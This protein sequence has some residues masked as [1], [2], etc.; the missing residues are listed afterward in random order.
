MLCAAGIS[1][2]AQTVVDVQPVDSAYLVQLEQIML[3]MEK[4]EKARKIIADYEKTMLR[5]ELSFNATGSM[6][7][8][9]G[10]M[11]T[12][13]NNDYRK[14]APKF[15]D[16]SDDWRDYA[17]ASIPGVAT[18][19]ARLC[20][21]KSRSNLN[22]MFT[23]TAMSLAL[24][25]GITSGLKNIVSE[26]RPDW[27]DDHSMPSRH[28]A[29]AFTAATILH[30]E[31]GYLSPWVSV[32]GYAAATATQFLRLRDNAHWLNDLYVGAAIG[33]VS[34][35]FGYFLTDRIFGEDG[36]AVKPKVT[37]ADMRRAARFEEGPTSFCM[38]S[39]SEF[40][41]GEKLECERT[42]FVGGEFS[43]FFNEYVAGEGI[44]KVSSTKVNEL[45]DNLLMYHADA[46]MKLSYPIMPGF[47]VNGRAL[48]GGRFSEKKQFIDD[49]S[50][51]VGCGCGFDFLHKEKY[52]VGLSMDYYHV[53]SDIMKDRL[54]VGATY[55]VVF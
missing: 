49:R 28:T 24:S 30:R 7:I 34:A 33:T 22:R 52:S 25:A 48:C 1:C 32:G 55:R 45:Q 40:G 31:Y 10:L 3:Q 27:S 37:E 17:I 23:S 50:L 38:V 15:T 12:S 53:F 35:N 14:N 5:R 13:L 44:L 39:G 51:E 46:A 26:R 6:Q 21:V 16:T 43:Y 2:S 4:E 8:L 18:Y 36:I 29:L 9:S 41:L 11:L 20:G 42:F 47:K 54:A 19:M